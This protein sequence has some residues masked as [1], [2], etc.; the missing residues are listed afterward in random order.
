MYGALTLITMEL[1][2]KRILIAIGMLLT[3]V[4]LHAATPTLSDVQEALARG[5]YAT[6]ESLVSQAVVAD[7]K[8][9]R[10]HYVFA[11]LLANSGKFGVAQEQLSLAQQMDPAITITDQAKFRALAN[12]LS[13]ANHRDVTSSIPKPSSIA[14]TDSSE[15]VVNPATQNIVFGIALLLAA[16]VIAVLVFS[17]ND[18]VP[19][20]SF[21]SQSNSSRYQQSPPHVQ[22]PI[23]V[24]TGGGAGSGIADGL[25]GVAVGMLLESA[26]EDRSASVP[27]VDDGA[28]Q[29]RADLESRPVDLG[30]DHAEDWSAGDSGGASIDMGN[31]SDF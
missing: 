16:V 28:D 15:N 24:A 13:L 7:P 19:D 8:N 6:A 5:D 30:N 3:A 21:Q 11:G 31:G 10:D 17:D 27:D 20:S 23:Y 22:S 1:R 29:A 2:V 26:L 25:T 9:A 12:E 4:G 14:A 18:D